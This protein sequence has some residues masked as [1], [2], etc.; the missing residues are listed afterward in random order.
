MLVSLLVFFQVQN[1]CVSCENIFVDVI[2]GLIDY[3]FVIY[4][5]V[6]LLN[7]VRC[8]E[9]FCLGERHL[10]RWIL[11]KLRRISIFLNWVDIFLFISFPILI[12]SHFPNSIFDLISQI[13]SHYF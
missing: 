13:H 9:Q 4:Y 8:V 10:K 1:N 6:L 2:N 11:G 7:F 3:T 12:K 5:H